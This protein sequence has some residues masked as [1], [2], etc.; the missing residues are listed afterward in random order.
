MLEE[1]TALLRL[2]AQYGDTAIVGRLAAGHGLVA[3]RFGPVAQALAPGAL[4]D[5]VVR[6]RSQV[7][8]VV[9]GGRLAVSDGVLVNGDVESTPPRHGARPRDYGNVF[10]R[11]Q[12]ADFA[13][14]IGQCWAAQRGTTL[15]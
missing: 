10:R 7:R 13:E 11:S 1:E 3:E 8:H 15:A 5:V 4:G 12:P 6:E 14:K 2:A 9:V